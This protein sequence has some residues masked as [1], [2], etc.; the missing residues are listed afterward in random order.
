MRII[1]TVVILMALAG[2]LVGCLGPK[3][4]K[5]KLPDNAVNN[6]EMI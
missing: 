2:A 1:T 4:G 5:M 6:Q 3:G